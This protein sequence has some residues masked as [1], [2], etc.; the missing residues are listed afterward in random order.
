MQDV[1]SREPREGKRQTV[2]EDI[3]KWH[4]RQ[5]VSQALENLR[6][7]L[8]SFPQGSVENTEEIEILLAPC[9]EKLAGRQGGM[10]TGELHRRTEN[11]EC[12]LV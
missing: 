11:M 8:A 4:A 5:I 7:R 10:E 12:A 6:N 3:A 1:T 9:W 2:P